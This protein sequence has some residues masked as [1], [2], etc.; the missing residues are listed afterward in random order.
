VLGWR[1][2]FMN[3]NLTANWLTVYN[4]TH[5]SYQHSLFL[6]YKV[7]GRISVSLDTFFLKVKD[8]DN[9]LSPYRNQNAAVFRFLYQF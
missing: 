5:P 2:N 1:N 6:S 7:N 8:R 9:E 3:D 4:Q